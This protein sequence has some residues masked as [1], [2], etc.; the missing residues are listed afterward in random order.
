MNMKK[1]KTLSDIQRNCSSLCSHCIS[2]TDRNPACHRTGRSLCLSPGNSTGL[3][4]GVYLA[5][6]YGTS[7][8]GHPRR[9][10]WRSLCVLSLE[11]H[12]L[13]E[14]AYCICRSMQNWERN[15]IRT[16]QYTALSLLWMPTLRSCINSCFIPVVN[17]DGTHDYTCISHHRSTQ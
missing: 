8:G 1:I 6:P 17:L 4:A 5:A 16:D 10:P 9:P 11:K 14:P 7:Q 15:R 13:P 12:F 3:A 2:T